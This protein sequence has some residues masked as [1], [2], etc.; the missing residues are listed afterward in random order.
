MQVLQRGQSL[1]ITVR[2]GCRAS[3]PAGLG[4]S[5]RTTPPLVSL[6]AASHSE[7]SAARPGRRP[8]SSPSQCAA[9]AGCPG[10][11]L[12]RTRCW[13]ASAARAATPARGGGAHEGRGTRG[14]GHTRGRAHSTSVSATSYSMLHYLLLSRLALLG[15]TS[16]QLDVL[17]HILGMTRTLVTVPGDSAP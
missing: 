9:C 14:A 5:E 13:D 8:R 11:T 2:C 3:S 1:L 10:R 7:P 17:H 6:A 4:Q 12:C 16:C 15:P